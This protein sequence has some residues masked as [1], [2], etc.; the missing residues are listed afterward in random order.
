MILQ[1]KRTQVVIYL[2][3][4]V[5]ALFTSTQL[6]LKTLEAG[7]S[8]TWGKLFLIQFLVW[9]IWAGLSPLIFWLGKRFRIDRQTYYGGL[10]LHIVFA[11][12]IVL[13]YLALY[14]LIWNFLGI[15]AFSWDAFKLYFKVF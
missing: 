14:S 9:N 4:V 1:A 10:L 15:G 2:F 5:A 12:A 6:Y 13:M 8:D 11:V 3:W 7:G